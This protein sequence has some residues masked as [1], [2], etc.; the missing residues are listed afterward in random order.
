MRTASANAPKPRLT[1]FQKLASF[2]FA[3]QRPLSARF[4]LADVYNNFMTG[5]CHPF[6]VSHFVIP[7]VKTYYPANARARLAGDGVTAR[8]CDSAGTI[9][10]ATRH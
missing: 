4:Q 6:F 5:I 2:C 8:N 10:E 1:P 9:E 3:V 7:S